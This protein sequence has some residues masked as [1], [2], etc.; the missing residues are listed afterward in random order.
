[1]KFIAGSIGM[2]L[3]ASTATKA[4]TVTLDY[5]FNNEYK[6]N[7]TTG[8]LERFH[9]TWE[10]KAS[11]GYSIWG[12][13]FKMNGATLKSLEVAPTKENLKGTSVYIIVDP[14]TKKE[15]ADPHYIQAEDIKNIAAWVKSGGVLVLLA[16]DSANCELEHLNHLSETFGIHFNND[17]RNTVVGNQ[18]EMAS[19]KV[20]DE[21]PIFKTAKKIYMKEISTLRVEA[22][23]VPEF[24]DRND[25]IIAV[26]KYGRGT[27]FAVGDPW[28]YNEYCNGRL[29]MGY[30]NDKAADD[31][32]KWLLKQAHK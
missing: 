26:A 20:R 15:T 5:Y 9:Y 6:K 13:I 28:F 2:L 16:N 4:Q 30:D 22:P 19:F 27:V 14:D 17:L 3:L 24:V 10:D 8:Q 29:P 12:D 18:F 25:I 31:L 23:A 21:D 32:A 7:A 1:M 11:S